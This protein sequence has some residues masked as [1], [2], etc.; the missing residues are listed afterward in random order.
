MRECHKLVIPVT[1]RGRGRGF[2][3]FLRG[4]P[5]AD[6]RLE[7]NITYTK[8]SMQYYKDNN[9]LRDDINL[10]GCSACQLQDG[11][12]VCENRTRVV[13]ITLATGEAIMFACH[14][15]V[16]LKKALKVG[17]TKRGS[18]CLS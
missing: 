9:E 11:S 13:Q 14:T 8:S 6:R 7:M 18:A 15:E 12:T 2:F 5:W 16:D 1:K 17:H 10:M 3:G 4:H